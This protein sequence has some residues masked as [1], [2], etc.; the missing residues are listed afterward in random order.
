MNARAEH[1][2]SSL[3]SIPKHAGWLFAL[4][5]ILAV[6]FGA[7]ALRSPSAAA[8]AI[9]VVFA[10]YAFADGFLDFVLAAR[11]GRSGQRWGWYVF[12]GLATVAIGVVALAYPA[13]TLFALVLL[14]AIRAIAVGVFELVGAFS[15]DG[16]LYSEDHDSRWLL[17]ITGALSVVLGILLLGSPVVGAMALIWAIGLYAIIY[18]MMLFAFGLR[19]F[20]TL[21]RAER[22]V[23]H[24]RGPAATAQ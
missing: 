1:F 23:E 15:S 2:R 7:I 10:I 20:S 18:G 9:V 11:L 14:V 16:P 13:V 3:E 22:E 24:M 12:E 17:G 4:R 19:I 6:I 5:G 8:A 21:H